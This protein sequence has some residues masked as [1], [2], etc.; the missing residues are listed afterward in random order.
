MPFATITHRADRSPPLFVAIESAVAEAP[1]GAARELGTGHG[2]VLARLRQAI[3]EHDRHRPSPPEQ[4]T[5]ADRTA[6]PVTSG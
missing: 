5:S 6:V 3:R 1:A 4:P 2:P